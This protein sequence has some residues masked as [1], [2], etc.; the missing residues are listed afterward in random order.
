MKSE[1]EC[2]GIL[3]REVALAEIGAP[4]EALD[5]QVEDNVTLGDMILGNIVPLDHIVEALPQIRYTEAQ[6]GVADSI[7]ARLVCQSDYE[8]R[9][10]TLSVKRLPEDAPYRT[11]RPANRHWLTTFDS[12]VSECP[13]A[14]SLYSQ[15][16]M[17]VIGS[18][19]PK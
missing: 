16:F 13:G 1:A 8:E 6:L 2:V 19:V 11:A 7:A 12:R 17:E 4:M 14:D 9:G 10:L 18:T 5:R 15:R 3:A